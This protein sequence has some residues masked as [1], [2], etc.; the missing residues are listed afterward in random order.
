[1]RLDQDHRKWQRLAEL[2]TLALLVAGWLCL[3]FVMDRDLAEGSDSDRR[4]QALRLWLEEG[5]R[6]A[7]KWPLIGTVLGTPFFYLG[8]IIRTPEWW[9]YAYPALIAGASLVILDV[10][11]KPHLE[12]AP[13]R[14]FLLLLLMAS[15]VPYQLRSL[16]AE[17]FNLFL[18]AIGFVALLEERWV[19]GFVAVALGGANMPATLGGVGLALVV[20]ALM[21]RRWRV[22]LPGVLAVLITVGENWF[23]YGSPFETPYAEGIE[24]GYRT[25]LPYSGQPGFSYP[26]LFGVVSLVFSF[27]KGILFFAPG[28]FL[29]LRPA[30][31][32]LPVLLTRLRWVWV[33]HVIGLVIVYSK[34]WAWYGGFTWGPRFLA[35]ASVP[36]ALILA[37]KVERPSERLLEN[38]AVI[39]VLALS[40]WVG[41]CSSVFGLYGQGFCTENHYALESFC[42][43]LPEYSVLSRA[44]VMDYPMPTSQWLLVAVCVS[45]FVVSAAPLVPVVA[46]QFRAAWRDGA[47]WFRAQ[48]FRF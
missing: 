38:L 46:R 11:L 32:G 30:A 2:G 5:V 9:M 20:T 3:V 12:T 45:T 28:L 6:P 33:T 27:G 43:Y 4:F 31:E 1:M 15:M 47:H 25:A 34:W 13:R 24:H 16:S 10:L 22:V 44:V 18:L 36:A 14:R 8:R 7:V 26:M 48:S 37:L 42:W 40:A 17:T 19:S 39:L 29:P 23:K 35:F 41:L 21:L